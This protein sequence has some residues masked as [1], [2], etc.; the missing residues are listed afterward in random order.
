MN[1]ES[2]R[3]RIWSLMTEQKVVRF[4]GADGRIPNFVGAEEAARKLAETPE[5]KAAKTLKCNPDSPQHPV[6]T[7]ALKEGKTVYMAVPRL[8]E[9]KCFIKLDPERARGRERDAAS[10]KGASRYGR[11]VEPKDM[12]HIDLIV[13]GSVAVRYDGARL[14]KG[15]G[16]SDLEF[17][18]AKE[19]GLVDEKTTIV[20]T[21]HP[22]QLTVLPFDMTVHD[23]PLD[24]IVTSQQTI[25]CPK[26]FP[27]PTGILWDRLSKEKIDQIPIL[28]SRLRDRK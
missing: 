28:Q 17:G 21:V 18:L 15:G 10:I 16:Y 13:A 23:I 3:Q 14:G 20:T 6:R 5:W 27:R 7:R 22:I 2:V 11:K 19:L 25:R 12:P 24:I 1:K 26:Q 4:P 8:R 9:K